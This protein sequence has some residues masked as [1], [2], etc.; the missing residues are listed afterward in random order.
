MPVSGSAHARRAKMRAACAEGCFIRER[1]SA[2]GF[3]QSDIT[4]NVCMLTGKL[5]GK[6]YDWWWHS[7]TGQ[8]RRTGKE[9]SFFIEFYL[10]NRKLDCNEKTQRFPLRFGK[11]FQHN[12]LL[13]CD[14]VKGGRKPVFG[15]L[16]ENR[17]AGRKP[18]YLMVKA[19]AWGEDAAQLHRFFGWQDVAVDWKAPFALAAEDCYLSETATKG[20]ILVTEE[21]AAAHPE[22]M[23]QAGRMSW[24]LKIRKKIPFNAG[25]G[26]GKLLRALNAFEMYWHAEGMKTEYSGTVRWN[27]EEYDVIPESSYGYADKNWGSDFTSPWV[28]LSSNHLVS[29]FTGRA[30]GNSAFVIGGGRPR[31]FGIPL[32][33]RLLGA[34]Y[35]EGKEYEFNFSKLWDLV[36]TKFDCRETKDE[37]IWRVRQE[38]RTAL[39][40][41]E[42]RCKRK[43]MLFINYEAPD[44]SRRHDRLWNGGTGTGRIRLYR[45]EG[46]YRILVDDVYVKNAGCEYGE[47]DGNF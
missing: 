21:D 42:I 11:L 37:I 33:R 44:G 4:R 12:G 10:C 16:P 5:A 2:M 41:T 8:S 15:Q 36:R 23:C 32:N 13:H 40:H 1:V 34:F 47:Y 14:S 20:R 24:N 26:A 9:K 7:F 3:S 39:M 25:Y 31:I 27:G 29:R 30:L 22:Y 28:W 6:G 38:S 18:S 35:Y 19:G 45:K 46:I 43:D 17:E